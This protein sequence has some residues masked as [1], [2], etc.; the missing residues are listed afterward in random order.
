MPHK[1]KLN[2]H[3]FNVE[4]YN[5]TNTFCVNNHFTSAH[6]CWIVGL[7]RFLFNILNA[8]TIF[9]FLIRGTHFL[10]W[11]RSQ[12][13]YGFNWFYLR[14]CLVQW[15]E[16]FSSSVN[17]H[18][19]PETVD[20]LSS[21]TQSELIWNQIDYFKR[22]KVDCFY[23]ACMQSTV[24]EEINSH[25]EAG[26]F[27]IVVQPAQYSNDLWLISDARTPTITVIYKAT[28]YLLRFTASM[29]SWYVKL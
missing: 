11:K 8:K 27:K 12:L 22:C 18:N 9:G 21:F 19:S 7:L 20:A 24:S 2:E 13:G 5:E 26:F 6:L 10:S 1:K 23:F 4:S 28:S 25:W 15:H 17:I 14:T 16:M 3:L 29:F